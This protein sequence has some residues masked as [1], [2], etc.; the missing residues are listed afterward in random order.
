MQRTCG[1]CQLCCT[2]APVHEIEKL[3]FQRCKHLCDSGCSIYSE[4]PKSCRVWSCAWLLTDML[5][6]ERPDHSH[7]VVNPILDTLAAEG[8][9]GKIIH[10]EAVEIWCDPA[11]P[12]AH[13]DPKL[14]AFLLTTKPQGLACIRFGSDDSAILLVPPSLSTTGNWEERKSTPTD[15]LPE[16][17]PHEKQRS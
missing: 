15:K 13:R 5:I 17:T 10:F 4:R 6:A 1:E 3:P 11:Y 2:L 7:Y 9:N 16:E 14:R 8:D 12:D